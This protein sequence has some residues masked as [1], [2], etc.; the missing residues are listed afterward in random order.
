MNFLAR[1]IPARVHAALRLLKYRFQIYLGTFRSPEPEW[2]RLR[3]WVKPGDSVIDIGANVGH[4]TRELLKIVGKEGLVTAFE[5]VPV[6]F[7]ILSRLVRG[8][9]NVSLHS[10]AAS[11]HDGE[12][13]MCVPGRNYY[14]AHIRDGG[15]IPVKTCAID[16]LNLE[17]ADF[18][19]IDAEGHE[20]KILEGMKGLLGRFHPVLLIENSGKGIADFLAPFGCRK[21]QLTGSPN[22]VFIPAPS[23]AQ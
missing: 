8:A 3:E 23:P 9:P 11:D 21:L 7:A 15:D 5:P 22:L 10:C 4:Y 12:C 1:L 20:L 2:D 13:A 18:V 16:H 6:T 17:S 14:R 19:K